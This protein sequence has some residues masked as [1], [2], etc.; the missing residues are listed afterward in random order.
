[1]NSTEVPHRSGSERP[2]FEAPGA[3][4]R[5]KANRSVFGV[6]TGKT[7]PAGPWVMVQVEFGL[8]D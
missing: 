7:R 1:M 8:G 4:V 6:T 3:C 5:L 2:D